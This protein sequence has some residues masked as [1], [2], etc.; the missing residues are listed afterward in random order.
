MNIDI[1]IREHIK[2]T[3]SNEL[4]MAVARRR[5][6]GAYLTKRPEYRKFEADMAEALSKRISEEEINLLK[7]ELESNYKLSIRV[8]LK[9]GM[10]ET[11]FYRS[12]V[13]NMIKATEDCI[14]NHIKVDDTRNTI[15]LSE[16]YILRSSTDIDDWQLDIKL[17]TVENDYIW[18]DKWSKRVK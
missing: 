8:E 14:K 7:E 12:D 9:I 6:V 16:K 10:S 13:S 17:S 2:P 3:S 5:H 18:E 15:I 1:S 4:Y 11:D